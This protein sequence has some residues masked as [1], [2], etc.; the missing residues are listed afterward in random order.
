MRRR[1]VAALTGVAIVTL[2]LYAGP[3]AFMLAG[4]IRGQ[5]ER[6][7]GRST[8]LVATS[9]EA[10]LL[11]G[12]PVDEAFLRELVADGEELEVSFPDGDVLVVGANDPGVPTVSATQPMSSGGS[13]TMRLTSRVVDE[14]VAQ[15]MV[16]V[17]VIGAS[18]LLFAVA[19]ALVLSRQLARPF[20]RLADYA[21]RLGEDDD[22]PPPHTGIPEADQLAGA[23]DASRVRVQQLLRQEREFSSNASHQM[24]T[25]LAALRLRLEDLT[26][27]PDV[28]ADVRHELELSLREIDRLADTVT[29]LLQLARSGR[30]GGWTEFDLCGLVED[31]VGRWEHRFKAIGRRIVLLPADGR[32]WVATSERAVEQVLEVVLENALV[33]GAG[34]VDV[35]VQELEHRAAV[36]VCDEG[37]VERE[38]SGRM[39]ERSFRSTSSTGSGIGLALAQTIAESAGVRLGLV[40]RDPTVFE[41]SLAVRRPA[42]EDASERR[43]SRSRSAG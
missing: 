40:S 38:V 2:L 39:F 19:L 6:A 7:L 5:E 37:S 17:V 18:S 4:L 29:G 31:V 33:H 32:P 30:L 21:A 20:T 1:L 10:R 41:L 22:L 42:A 43:S 14:R 8:E 26:M 16:P 13:V 9:V 3:R 28:H 25:P 34:A 15:A 12:V 24:R 11:A 27:W 36:R 23:L 35:H